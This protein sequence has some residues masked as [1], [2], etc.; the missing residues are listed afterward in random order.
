MRS[1][2]SFATPNGGLTYKRIEWASWSR[3]GDPDRGLAPHFSCDKQVM[4]VPD[5][6]DHACPQ[7]LLTPVSLP[8]REPAQFP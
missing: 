2:R 5:F 3:F 6:P 1:L 7:P 8:I 4:P